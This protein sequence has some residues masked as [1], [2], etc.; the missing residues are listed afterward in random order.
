MAKIDEVLHRNWAQIK[1]RHPDI[2][3]VG[4]STKWADGKD[5]GRPSITIFVKKKLPTAQLAESEKIPEQIEGIETDV[6][7]LAPTTWKADHTAIS[8]LSPAQQR[9]LL[10]L[11]QRPIQYKS[12]RT[13]LNAPAPS[14]A[15]DHSRFASSIQDQ[16]NC[17]DCTSEGNTGVWEI[18]LHQATPGDTTKLSVSHLFRCSGGTCSGG[19]TVEATLNR[20]MIGVCLESCLP[21]KDVD[22]ACGAGICANWW[23]TA[24]KLA[25]W[26]AIT[27]PN[28]Q[29]VL[30][31][32]E[33]LNCTMAVHQ[34]YFNYV[35]G[36]Y[37]NLGA[38]DPI[39]G[40]H[41]QG[42]IGYVYNATRNVKL[43]R[44]S[45]GIFWGA[46]CLDLKGN[47]IPGNCW[48]DAGE[49][50][51]EMQQL[52]LSNDPVTPPTGTLQILTTSLPDATVRYPYLASL[53][54]SGGT[55]PYKW[56]IEAGA[57]P[58]GLALSASGV[59]SGTP[60][61]T[62]QVTI[63]FLVTDSA[64]LSDDAALTLQIIAMIEIT[65]TSLP[66]GTVGTP[67]SFNLAASGGVPPYQWFIESPLPPGLTMDR[68]SGVISGTPTTAGQTTIT[69][70]VTHT[71]NN[72]GDATLFL[73]INAAPPP[74]PPPNPTPTPPTPTPSKCK[75][76]SKTLATLTKL[77]KR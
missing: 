19:N 54:A 59:I 48:I 8:K 12:L 27:D 16:G 74:T 4:V 28:E 43:L 14:G 23:L 51:P 71:R 22:G 11:S 55:P 61:A 66:A 2:L 63:T 75:C 18:K 10:G 7:E 15:A 57:L 76:W 21:T 13:M 46:G 31:D 17:G 36:D 25:V 3:N 41:D 29:L 65:T 9:K 68:S 77:W 70:M 24:K 33:P 50:D 40:Y 26:N 73:Q 67:Y 35:S 72:P 56:S 5:T 30:L 42:A 60:T 69:F 58:A 38:S 32:S 20:A 53:V 49:L 62:G 1:A 39:V 52:I 64:G 45:W 37:K 44:N 47:P 34:S 6:V